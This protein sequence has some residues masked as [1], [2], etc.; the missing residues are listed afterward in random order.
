MADVTLEEASSPLAVREGLVVGLGQLYHS[1][2]EM[3]NG[4]LDA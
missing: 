2:Q 3:V 1:M 4:S